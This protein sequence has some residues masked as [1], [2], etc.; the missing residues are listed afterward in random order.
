MKL[1]STRLIKISAGKYFLFIFVLL[2][3]SSPLSNSQNIEPRF[4]HLT[5][6]DGLPE[7]SAKAILQDYLGYMWFG[8]QAGLVKYD[9]YDMTIYNWSAD[10]DS[11]LSSGSIMSIYEDRKKNL[12]IGTWASGLNR[13]NRTTETFKSFLHNP[14][15]PSSLGSD[16]IY[17]SYEDK[18]GR[19]WIGTD[20]GLELLDI[21]SNKFKHFY[22]LDRSYSSELFDYILKNSK[23]N[24]KVE[25]ILKVGNNADITKTFIVKKK[26]PVLIVSIGEAGY[27]YGWL[28]DSKGNILFNYDYEKTQHAGGALNNRI[29]FALIT[30]DEGTYKLHYTSNYFYSYE[31][32]FV[33]AWSWDY[34]RRTGKPPDSPEFWGIQILDASA[35]IKMLEGSLKNSTTI[36]VKSRVFAIIG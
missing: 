20:E 14:N 18:K 4:E 34:K 23:S 6:K 26:M 32:Q 28:E 2:I 24:S 3:T 36:E 9:G 30:L 15:D 7:N 12:W 10:I 25:S 16:I 8:T 1:A 13:F 27:D 19:L 31:D 21:K 5:V 33:H 35:D 29:Q 11:S 22:F 17:T